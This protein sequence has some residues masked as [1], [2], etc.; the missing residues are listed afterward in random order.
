MHAWFSNTTLC[1]LR[2][3][4]GLHT[5]HILK[6]QHNAEPEVCKAEV[7]DVCGL[8]Y[9]EETMIVIGWQSS[10]NRS[11]SFNVHTRPGLGGYAPSPSANLLVLREQ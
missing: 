10:F 5:V 7:T 2:K 3:P 6:Q 11:N 4:P 9:I 1:L 8:S